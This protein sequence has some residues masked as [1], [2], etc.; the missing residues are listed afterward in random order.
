MRDGAVRVS[1]LA[2]LVWL[3]LSVPVLAACVGENLVEKYRGEDPAAIDAMFSRAHGV[4]NGT[5]NL[6]EIR[7]PGVEPS[8]LVGTFHAADAIELVPDRVWDLLNGAKTAVFEVDAEQRA[9]LEHRLHTD[10]SYILD[11]EAPPLADRLPPGTVADVTA[12]LRARGM[13]LE[14]ATQMRPWFLM[15]LLGFPPCHLLASA[16]GAEPLDHVMA[17]RA[18]D[19]GIPVL[20]LETFDQ[21]ID[22]LRGIDPDSLWEE[23]A[24]AASADAMAEDVY[25]TNLDLYAQGETQAILE[26]AYW[27]SD[28]LYPDRDNRTRIDAMMGRILDY[29]NRRW[30]SRLTGAVDQG[31]AFIAVGALHLPGDAGLVELLR[32]QGYKVS[33]LD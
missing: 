17:D 27:V 24:L 25:R 28:R 21:A 33:K 19:Q 3:C 6:W 23:I 12:A 10:P 15:S 18:L 30:M 7:A 1:W 2:G 26:F 16:R 4:A 29:R 13:S 5:G 22:A 31:G 9:A 20:G 32:Q 14:A 11:G 8:Y